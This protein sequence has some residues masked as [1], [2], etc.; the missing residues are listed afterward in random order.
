M[1]K[2]ALP[3]SSQCSDTA[4]GRAG[5]AD[6]TSNQALFQIF[7]Q[8]AASCSWP[9]RFCLPRV[10]PPAPCILPR[11]AHQRQAGAPQR[12]C[13]RG[14]RSTPQ[15][16]TTSPRR[17]ERRCGC[18]AWSP[19]RS[20]RRRPAEMTPPLVRTQLP[21]ARPTTYGQNRDPGQSTANGEFPGVGR[22]ICQSRGVDFLD[23]SW[24]DF[25]LLNHGE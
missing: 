16:H 10:P 5:S 7:L 17:G 22:A 8:G 6:W 2:L 18:A 15:A 25:G 9:V 14:Q 19:A 24:N 12:C 20:W 3:S 21:S 13:P 1:L 23:Y 4:G 11:F